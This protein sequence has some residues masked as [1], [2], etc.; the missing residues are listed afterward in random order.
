MLILNFIIST[1]PSIYNEYNRMILTKEYKDID[2]N[3]I[4][5]KKKW[6]Y[7]LV[8]IFAFCFHFIAWYYVTVFCSVYTKSSVSWICGGIISLI[9]KFFIIQ[10]LIPLFKAIFRWMTY[11]Y[12]KK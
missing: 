3:F 8:F 12:Q 10:P 4:L 1:P 5:K 7:L 6:R 11:K 2:K 9:I